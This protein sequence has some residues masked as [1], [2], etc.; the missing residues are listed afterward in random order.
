MPY[1]K[2]QLR[3]YWQA[4]KETINQKRRQ[5]RRLAKLLALGRVCHSLK[6]ANPNQVGHGKPTN[7]KLFLEMANP[8]LIKLIQKWQTHTNYNCVSTCA[9]SY[10]NNC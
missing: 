1:T 4:N 6:M 8:Q 3:A 9:Y 5:K 7:G 10:C 2:E